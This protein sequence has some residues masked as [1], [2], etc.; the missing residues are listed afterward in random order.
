MPKAF[1]WILAAVTVLVLALFGLAIGVALTTQGRPSGALDTDLERR[2][3]LRPDHTR[4]DAAPAPVEPT[5]DRRCWRT[6]GG[7]A[8]RSLARPEATSRS[9]GA[10]PPGREPWVTSSSTRRLLRRASYRESRTRRD[11]R[12]RRAIGTDAVEA[13]RTRRR[14]R[15]LRS[16]ASAC[17]SAPTTERSRLSAASGEASV[18][19]RGSA[20]V[21]SSPV[22]VDGVA[23]FGAR[24]RAC[25]P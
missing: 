1:A 16:T 9:P 23:Y 19:G 5:S 6:F 14:P 3:G 7:D 2:F 22:V 11:G 21:E 13:G 25:S 17:S 12:H 20:A 8:R 15:A 10:S 4:A 18:A 24:R